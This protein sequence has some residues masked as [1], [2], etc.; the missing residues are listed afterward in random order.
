MSECA[1]KPDDHCPRWNQAV[2]AMG[3]MVCRGGDERS[4]ALYFRG[5]GSDPPAPPPD[6]AT[7]DEVA[8]MLACPH[9]WQD[10]SCRACQWPF[11]CRAK[12]DAK[13]KHADCAKCLRAGG[14]PT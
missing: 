12:A 3:V 10:L 4:Q 2:T 11:R 6:P 1:C 8:A 14:P 7:D 5:P 13:V 9:R